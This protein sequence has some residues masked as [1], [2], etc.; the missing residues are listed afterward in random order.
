MVLRFSWLLICE[1]EYFRLK[2]NTIKTI[3]YLK[4]CNGHK[5]ELFHFLNKI[6]CV[7]KFIFDIEFPELMCY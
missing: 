2:K 1:Y 4:F 6:S 5:I 7:F 3:N